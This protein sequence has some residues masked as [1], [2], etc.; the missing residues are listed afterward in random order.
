MGYPEEVEASYK[1][2]ERETRGLPLAEQDKSIAELQDSFAALVDRL[3][4]VL[5]PEPLSTP[6][7][8]VA[9]KAES[10]QSPLARELEG[11]NFRIRRVTS[12]LNNVLDRLEV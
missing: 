6:D 7:N 10:M 11:H 1:A 12:R 4:T 8:E 2:K 3:E 5:T 9:A